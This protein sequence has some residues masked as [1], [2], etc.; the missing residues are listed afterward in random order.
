MILARCIVDPESRDEL[1]EA[2]AAFSRA[3]EDSREKWGWAI[4]EMSD[5]QIETLGRLRAAI[6]TLLG[7]L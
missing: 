3:I 5:A 6:E 2:D 7:N 1:R 4:D